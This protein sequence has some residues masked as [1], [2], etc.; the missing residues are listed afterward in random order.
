MMGPLADA[1]G[2]GSHLKEGSGEGLA[3]TKTTRYD[4]HTSPA[5]IQIIMNDL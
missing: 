2:P 1:Y 4:D 3:S 5:K